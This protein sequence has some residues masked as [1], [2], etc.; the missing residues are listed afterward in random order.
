MNKNN[1]VEPRIQHI[2]IHFIEK[3]QNKGKVKKKDLA[4]DLDNPTSEGVTNFIEGFCKTR[5]DINRSIAYASFLEELESKYRYDIRPIKDM[6]IEY[7]AGKK[8]DKDFLNLSIEIAERYIRCLETTRLSTGDHMIV[9]D[10]IDQ[11]NKP[12]FGITLLG[13]E[14]SSYVE[15][16]KLKTSLAL[17]LKQ[18]TLAAIIDL[19]RWLNP[20]EGDPANYISF[21]CGTKDLSEY[22]R[23]GFI[24]CEKISRSSKATSDFMTAAELLAKDKLNLTQNEWENI[25]D[26]VA[27]HMH[28][29]KQEVIVL[30]LLNIMFPNPNDQAEFYK[31]ADENNL[32]ISA[33]FKPNQTAMKRWEKLVYNKNGIKIEA[34]QD[35]IDDGTVTYE[36]GRLIILDP[37]GAIAREYE[38]FRRQE[39]E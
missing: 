21:I 7:E 16:H 17:N 24:G 22:Y 15:G 3:E 25:R 37:E 11:N 30:H 10:Y 14:F 6:I 38:N 4:K 27:S 12:M 28:E 18:M 23:E 26:K 1:E 35:R 2:A 34:S 13:Q 33:S 32:L 36:D 39:N 8:T 19:D 9:F 5:A 29:N 31:I 20:K